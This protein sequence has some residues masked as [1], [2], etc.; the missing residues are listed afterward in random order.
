MRNGPLFGRRLLALPEVGFQN[1]VVVPDQALLI[2]REGDSRL[3]RC[4]ETAT[5][6]P[7]IFVVLVEKRRE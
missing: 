7:D 5:L 3:D 1:H 4:P 6:P 2:V